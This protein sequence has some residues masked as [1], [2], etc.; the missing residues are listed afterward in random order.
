MYEN[1]KVKQ[2]NDEQQKIINV[3]ETIDNMMKEQASKDTDNTSYNVV[4]LSKQNDKNTN[5]N[6]DSVLCGQT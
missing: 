5:N 4:D 3:L 6:C 2:K 1:Y